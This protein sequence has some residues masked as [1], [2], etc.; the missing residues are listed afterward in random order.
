MT[1]MRRQ[2]P[3]WENIFANHM[4]NK[5]LVFRLYEEFLQLKSHNKQF[6]LKWVKDLNDISLKKYKWPISLRK[7]ALYH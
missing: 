7:H 4:F 1:K 3:G 6:I 5:S 2:P